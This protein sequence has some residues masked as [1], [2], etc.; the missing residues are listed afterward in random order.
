[1][2]EADKLVDL[3]YGSLQ[4]VRR[5]QKYYLAIL[6]AFLALVWVGQIGAGKPRATVSIDTD[7][8]SVPKSAPVSGRNL[9]E[10]TPGITTILL[11][12]LVG[13]LRAT[14]PALK[15]FQ[16]AWASAGGRAEAVGLAAIDTHRS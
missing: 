9:L 7:T 3:Y 12:G 10:A 4:A 11:L 15:R 14:E 2:N 5:A 1:M 6:L 8:V 13:C 16:D